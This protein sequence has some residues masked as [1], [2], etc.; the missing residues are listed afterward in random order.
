[1]LA[2]VFRLER[3]LARTLRSS[4]RVGECGRTVDFQY[5]DMIAVG[6]EVEEGCRG[7]IGVG[8]SLLREADEAENRG[9]LCAPG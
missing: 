4:G 8:A 3:L 9:G 2:V 7:G 5:S 6:G 1:M